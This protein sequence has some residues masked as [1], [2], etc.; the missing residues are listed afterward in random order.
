MGMRLFW[1]GGG[2]WFVVGTNYNEG[3]IGVSHP[4]LGNNS[5]YEVTLTGINIRYYS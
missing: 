2:W 4:R 3:E 1:R 5:A